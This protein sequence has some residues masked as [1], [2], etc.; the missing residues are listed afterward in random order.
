MFKLVLRDY[1]TLYVTGPSQIHLGKVVAKVGLQAYT[2]NNILGR[3]YWDSHLN[4]SL[5]FEGKVGACRSGVTVATSSNHYWFLLSVGNLQRQPQQPDG[6]QQ[7]H[8]GRGQGHLV[9][10]L[11][12]LC[13]SRHRRRQSCSRSPCYLGLHWDVSTDGSPQHDRTSIQT[14]NRHNSLQNMD[15]LSW[16]GPSCLL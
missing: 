6:S 10:S 3:K 1:S 13:R 12:G 15:N 11:L 16:Q 4:P 5:S 7:G 8:G 9:R 14:Q 2:S